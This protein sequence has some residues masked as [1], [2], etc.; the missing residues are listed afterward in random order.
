MR[1]V[2]LLSVREPAVPELDSQTEAE[3]LTEQNRSRG[4][5]QK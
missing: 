4:N 1:V 5:D 2:R 3:T